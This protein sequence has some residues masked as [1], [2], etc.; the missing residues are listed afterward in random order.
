MSGAV[1]VEAVFVQANPVWE[2]V[3]DETPGSSTL[4]R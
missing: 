2:Q 4:G 1:D 3:D